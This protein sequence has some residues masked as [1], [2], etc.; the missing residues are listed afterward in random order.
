MDVIFVAGEDIDLAKLNAPTIS[1]AGSTFRAGY[2]RCSLM[3]TNTNAWTKTL[4]VG[5]DEFYLSFQGKLTSS[6][7]TVINFGENAVNLSVRLYIV[8][9]GGLGHFRVDDWAGG[10][11]VTRE[12]ASAAQSEDLVHYTIH[13]KRGAAGV[14]RFEFWQGE[15]RTINYTGTLGQAFGSIGYFWF[16]SS[17]SNGW[18]SEI[19]CHTKDT[20]SMSLVTLYPDA[21]G[22]VNTFIAGGFG[23]IDEI[24]EA[25]ADVIESDTAG[26]KALFNVSGLVAGSEN[27]LAVIVNNKALA[28]DSGPQSLIDKIKT[29]GVEYDGST[30]TLSTTYAPQIYVWEKD[31]G[32][33][34][35]WTRA[36]VGALQIGAET[37][38]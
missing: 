14:G 26:Q 24:T 7:L 27:V 3:G 4:A 28:G 34:D 22:D 30:N 16:G 38:A 25:T 5:V 32:T 6:N 37:A 31:P 8:F 36:A 17:A 13:L 1:T 21:A 18:Y 2:A 35:Y 12:T 29:G 11:W 10:A 19:I 23:D 9:S 20:R 15:T 33:T